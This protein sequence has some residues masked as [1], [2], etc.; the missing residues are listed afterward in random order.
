MGR[1]LPFFVRWMQLENILQNQ[2]ECLLLHSSAVTKKNSK[3]ISDFYKAI[4]L[5]E[6]K[7]AMVNLGCARNLVDAQVMLGYLK[8]EGHS[9]VRLED[10]EAAIVN[11]CGFP[12]PM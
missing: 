10:S 7:V 11:T 2:S 5:K 8:G 3:T 6:N 9:I 1:Q 4:G 12:N